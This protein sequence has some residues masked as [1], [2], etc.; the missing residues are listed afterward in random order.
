MESSSFNPEEIDHLPDQAGVYKYYNE[1]GALIYVGKAKNLRKRVSSYF[2]KGAGFNKKTIRMVREIK[3]I[4][5]T[6]L[7]SEF[8]AL[9]LENNLIKKTQPKYNILLKDDKT[10][11]YLLL[12]KEHFP[13]IYPTRNIIPAKGIYF[14]PFASVK[15]M[16]NVLDLIRTLFTIRTCNYDLRPDKIAEGKYK[17]CLEYH[18][19]NCLGPCEGLQEE[20]SYLRDIEQ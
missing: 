20:E 3:R 18:I 1:D 4:E 19:G 5:I 12:T 8:D 6:L 15:A 11:P 2:L 14:G 16:K 7:N 13:R 10:Y 9:L 17:V